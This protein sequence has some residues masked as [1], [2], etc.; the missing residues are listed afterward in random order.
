M[1]KSPVPQHR[2]FHLAIYR[3]HS[4]GDL[5]GTE[6]SGADVHVGR[7]ALHDRLHALHIGLPRTIGASVGVRHLNT[8]RNTL[9]AKLA[10]SHPL[11][12]LAVRNSLAYIASNRYLSRLRRKMQALFDKNLKKICQAAI[13]SQP[14]E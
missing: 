9:I 4:A 14:S 6:A 3:S 11:H 8:E 10:L 1:R 13:H 2:G 5:T 7:S 12:L